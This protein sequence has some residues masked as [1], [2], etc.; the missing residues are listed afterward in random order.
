MHAFHTD[1]CTLRAHVCY[2]CELFD[3]YCKFG[4][5]HGL[6][7]IR[8]PS[9][10][11]IE[12]FFW[13]GIFLTCLY[14]SGIVVKNTYLTGMTNEFQLVYNPRITPIWDIP[15]PAVIVCSSSPVRKSFFDLE[16]QKDAKFTFFSKMVCLNPSHFASG[17]YNSSIDEEFFEFLSDAATPCKDMIVNCYWKSEKIDCC[18]LFKPIITMMGQC[19]IFNSLPGE[20]MYP[21]YNPP[22]GEQYNF[23]DNLKFWDV[24]NGYPKRVRGHLEKVY[25]LW[26]DIEGPLM[27][28]T[29]DLVYPKEEFQFQCS[30][31]H[32]GF[33]VYVYPPD[34]SLETETFIRVPLNVHS[35]I[36]LYPTQ[37]R[38]ENSLRSLTI[39]ERDCAF[40]DEVQLEYFNFYTRSSCIVECFTKMSLQLCLNNNT[41]SNIARVSVYY[42][43][44][45]FNTIDRQK[46][47]NI[48]IT[49]SNCGGLLGLLLGFSLMSLYEVLYY[50][51][52]RPIR[53]VT[54]IFLANICER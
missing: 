10:P 14:I 29:M 39:D 45:Q 17:I 5:L 49:L 44:G 1:R 33:R 52:V 23:Y 6:R 18:T 48:D 37:V 2:L 21:F 19:Y 31:T 42:G 40:L 4:S 3:E 28:L 7:Y 25:P 27:G 32:T 34:K 38:T 46:T 13:L 22:P 16:K 35:N 53:K 11:R 41:G 9:L 24:D 47:S 8:D 50:A 51:I 54:G 15:F 43:I 36:K 26:T 12:Q 20:I 30:A